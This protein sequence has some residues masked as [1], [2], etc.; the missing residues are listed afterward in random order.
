MRTAHVR[1]ARERDVLISFLILFSSLVRKKSSAHADILR[2]FCGQLSGTDSLSPWRALFFAFRSCARLLALCERCVS[3]SGID[4][5][6]SRTLSHPL[7][8]SAEENL[9]TE[10]RPSISSAVTG[11]S[12]PSAEFVSTHPQNLMSA[13]TASAIEMSQ[14]LA[15]AI[16]C[17]SSAIP[18]LSLI[19]SSILG[20]SVTGA[21]QSL[22]EQTSA[23]SALPFQRLRYAVR[24]ATH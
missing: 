19:Q 14:V 18:F 9:R 11:R 22:S 15:I 24:F 23:G 13:R 2:T 4:T 12:L 1:T 17:L 6:R 3:K 7:S 10:T 16:T 5:A 20:P 8:S 21:C